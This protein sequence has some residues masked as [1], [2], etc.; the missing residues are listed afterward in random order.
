MDRKSSAQL[1]YT[2]PSFHVMCR[3]RGLQSSVYGEVRLWRFGTKPKHTAL[4]ENTSLY[5][6]M[7]EVSDKERKENMIK[8]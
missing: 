8:G 6:N 2:H 3:Q 4:M 7:S 5:S 1:N